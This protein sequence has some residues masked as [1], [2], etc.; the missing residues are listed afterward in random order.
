M[1]PKSRRLDNKSMATR[2]E[3]KTEALERMK[4]LRIMG[5]VCNEFRTHDIVNYSERQ[6]K[7]FDGILY[8]MDNEEKFTK[9]KNDFE[10]EYGGLVYHAQLIHTNIGDML[11]LLYV[12]KTK[13]EWKQDR[14]LL[15]HGD[16]YAYVYN[17]T[18][19]DLSE[20]GLIG[21]APKN[22]GITRTY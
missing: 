17:L 9:I 22:G 15:K 11:S 6:N 8:W 5:H 3:M 18:D 2:E 4:M 14:D 21:V 12:S 16:T 1:L 7:I 19:P 10:K 13:S 20:I